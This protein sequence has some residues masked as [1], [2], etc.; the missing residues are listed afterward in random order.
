MPPFLMELAVK[1]GSR[2]LAILAIIIAL[3]GLYFYWKHEV[4]TE[5]RNEAIADCNASKE[6]FRIDAEHFKLAKQQELDKLS[7]EQD[8]RMRNAIEIYVKHHE[9]ISN[10]PI[11]NSLRIKT[12]SASS[13]CSTVPGAD[14]GR[15]K[16]STGNT[17]IN[18][19]E[20][21]PENL[22]QLNAVISDIE[23]LELKCEKLVNSL[24]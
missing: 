10:T 23:R 6:K 5:A 15:S 9:L 21:S 7:K 3:T 4:S 11:A 22:R 24:P 12:S 2:A 20:L 14:Q 13:N 16:A 17:G 8:E 18:E 19:A 1:Y